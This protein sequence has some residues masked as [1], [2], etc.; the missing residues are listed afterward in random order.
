MRCTE[1][2]DVETQVSFLNFLIL[3]SMQGHSFGFEA[4]L[5]DDNVV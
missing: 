5:F 4:Q 1:Y 2:F 3:S